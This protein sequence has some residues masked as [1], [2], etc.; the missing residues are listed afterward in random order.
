[1]AKNAR[2]CVR[3]I[4]GTHR[5]RQIYFPDAIHLRPTPD[6]VRETLF[7]WLGQDLTQKTCL[8]LF[9][10]S[11]ALG[12]E[13]ASRY[14]K[15]VVMVELAKPVYLALQQNCSLLKLDNIVTLRQQSA[16]DYLAHSTTLFDVI[17]LDPPFHSPLLEQVLPLLPKHIATNGLI[18]IEAAQLPILPNT[19][20]WIKKSRAGEVEYGLV[21]QKEASSLL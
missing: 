6:R 21:G 1:M 19:M 11:G 16:L 2:N 9:S 8:D 13:A 10:G 3:L 7:N 4:S 12:F 14:A 17:F 15:T 18:Y 20:Q 5:R